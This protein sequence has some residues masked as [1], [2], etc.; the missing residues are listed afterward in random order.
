MGWCVPLVLQ[1]SKNYIESYGSAFLL[2]SNTNAQTPFNFADSNNINVSANTIVN[3]QFGVVTLESGGTITMANNKFVNVLCAAGTQNTRSFG[4][5]VP[6]TPVQ[7][8][9]VAG[10][11]FSGNTFTNTSACA[12]PLANL[13]QPYYLVNTTGVVGVIKTA[14]VTP[15]FITANSKLWV[16]FN[17]VSG[18]DPSG[19]PPVATPLPSPPLSS[20]SLSQ[21]L[22]PAG[23]AVL[24]TIP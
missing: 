13:A 3:S 15:Y 9:G 19:Q 8:S 21:L 10:I 12:Q 24:A 16:Y 18:G 6:Y 14:P 1:L 23:S 5:Q 17:S 11:T 2:G 7:V 4:W 20:A 22:G